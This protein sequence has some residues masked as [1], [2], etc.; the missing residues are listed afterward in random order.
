LLSLHRGSNHGS[1][2]IGARVAIANWKPSLATGEAVVQTTAVG[3]WARSADSVSGRERIYYDAAPMSS[4]PRP[5]FIGSVVVEV[6]DQHEMR[7]VKAEPPERVETEIPKWSKAH[8]F[9]KKS[10]PGPAIDYA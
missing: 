10:Y 5:L 8:A 1:I 9:S 4:V 3:S 6:E 7:R 2:A